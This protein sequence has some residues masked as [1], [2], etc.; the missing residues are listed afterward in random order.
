MSS[1]LRALKKLEEDGS[2]KNGVQEDLIARPGHRSRSGRKAMV[3][4]VVTV[5]LV[6]SLTAG[7]ILFRKPD[8]PVK[9]A[10]KPIAAAQP[11]LAENNFRPPVPAQKA[12]A[13][14][15]PQ[16]QTDID[17]VPTLQPV[18]SL[19]EHR[20]AQAE[21][22]G[23]PMMA[24]SAPGEEM[25]SRMA[26]DTRPGQTAETASSLESPGPA[27]SEDQMR[28]QYTPPAE[29]QPQVVTSQAAPPAVQASADDTPVLKDAN[30]NLQAI[31]WNKEKEKRIAVID[32]RICREG[33]SVG[34]YTL[35]QINPD[36][37][38]LSKAG[39]TG[40]IVFR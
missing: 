12:P 6:T 14:L 11:Q 23:I 13:R 24:Q 5:V 7:I 25:S 35:K 38:V 22:A 19:P 18:P 3:G 30:L 34:E 9:Q 1:I 15:Q 40:K 29:P 21:T 10:A 32:G 8:D 31:S 2:A 28:A 27:R 17:T 39:T 26:A 33:D 16:P 4:G 20:P 36:D 37:V